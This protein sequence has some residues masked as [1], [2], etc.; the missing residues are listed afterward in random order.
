MF[1]ALDLQSRQEH[2]WSP[3][4]AAKWGV[5]L[6][7]PRKVGNRQWAFL[8]FFNGFSNMGQFYDVRETCGLLGVGYRF[9]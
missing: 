1:V 5:W 8:S 2:D 7:N 3:N 6:G 4:V 9:R